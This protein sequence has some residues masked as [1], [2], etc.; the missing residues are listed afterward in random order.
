LPSG[1]TVLFAGLYWGGFSASASRNTAKLALPGGG[2][3]VI[4]AQQL[5]AIGSAY[6]GFLDVTSQVRTAGNGV[7]RVA[8]VL[9]SPGT[10][11]VWAGWSLVVVYHLATTLSRN[12][13]VADGF[14][15]AGPGN[16]VNLSVSG[17]LTPP[18]GTVQAGVGIVAYD[19]DAG[20]TGED[21]ILNSTTLSDALNPANN[22]FNSN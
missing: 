22:V 18:S 1:A 13:T 7:Y 19:G 17:F 10:S 20:H 3:T 12:L 4:T 21:L 2:Y 11:D 9:S 14:V 15:F 6:Q 5:D 16:S 8:G